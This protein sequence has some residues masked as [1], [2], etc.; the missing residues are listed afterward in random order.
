MSFLPRRMLLAAVSLAL[1]LVSVGARATQDVVP[2]GGR[3]HEEEPGVHFEEPEALGP[4]PC[5]G[6]SA[7]PFPCSQVDLL[8]FLPL[9][10]IGG[11][12]TAH[13]ND[14][15]GWTDPQ[16][17]R[18]YALMGLTTGTAFVDI[19]NPEAPV[20]LGLLPTQTLPSPWRD[21]K[22]YKNYAFIV[23]EA[24]GHG[25]QVFDLKRLRKVNAPPVIFSAVAHY[26]DNGVSNSHNIAIN[27]ETGFAYLLGTNSCGGGL[28]MVDIR[29]PR[30]PRF[31]GCFGG[32]GYTHDAQCVS[33]RGPDG[34]HVGREICFA[35]N[36]D[37][38]TVVDVTNKETPLMLSRTT[39]QGVSYTHQ[40]WTTEDQHFLL[41]DDELDERSFGHRTKTYIW[42]IVDLDAPRHIGTYQSKKKTIDHNQYIRDGFTYQANYQSG[43]RILDLSAVAGG[44]LREVAFFD[45]L[46]EGN[47]ARF[48][49]AWSVYPFFP[50]GVVIVSGI[51][52]GL[53]I[54]QPR[55]PR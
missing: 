54:L 24:P 40:C 52:Q 32:D 10:S 19:T 17:G 1:P 43:L 11:D 21:L 44:R 23:S 45:V 22:V 50:S 2:H 25:M 6:G 49:G 18:E 12:G 34:E 31:A 41:L 27:E 9:S 4:T 20:Y 26:E 47:A 42:D 35:A 46:P 13:G 38:L 3:H 36:E 37:T 15:W 48:N 8:S 55:L 7:G 5:Q 39:Y 29:K 33:Y 51:E 30:S 53:F 14:V 16:T 28:H